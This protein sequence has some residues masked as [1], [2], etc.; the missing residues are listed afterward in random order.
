MFE[1]DYIYFYCVS[2]SYIGRKR[3]YREPEPEVEGTSM[4]IWPNY[5]YWTLSY[6]ITYNGVQKLLDADPLSKMIPVDEF[7]PIMFDRHP[8]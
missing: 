3:L 7:I 6:M 8:E 5:S 2:F 1:L 4:L